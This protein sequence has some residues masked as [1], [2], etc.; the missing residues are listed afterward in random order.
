MVDDGPPSSDEHGWL[1]GATHDPADVARQ[2]DQ[3]AD[4][5]DGDLAAWRYDAPAVVA[6]MVAAW[7]DAARLDPTGAATPGEAPDVTVLDAG[8]GTGLVGRA[9]ADVGVSVIDGLDVSA[10]SLV[11]AR[12]RGGYRHLVEHDLTHVPLPVDTDVYDVAVC[13]G[14]LTYVPQTVAMLREL[15]RAVRP[16]GLLV[17][18]QRDDLWHQRDMPSVLADL[19]RTG[20][21]SLFEWTEPMAYLPGHG[22]FADRIGVRYVTA[23]VGTSGSA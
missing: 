21:L 17:V 19:R 22:D 13:V 1:A 9:L 4:T 8:C 2:Y 14:V 20:D 16:G 7:N 3:W 11:R 10:S 23:T 5:Y 12:D 15:C 18:T 6:G